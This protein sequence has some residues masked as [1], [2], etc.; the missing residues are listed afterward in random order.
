MYALY[1]VDGRDAGI[2]LSL[3]E[4]LVARLPYE[5][6]SVWRARTLLGG[7]EWFGWSMAE[8]QRADLIDL[9][10]LTMRACAQQGA[11]LRPSEAS[12]RPGGVEKKKE[13]ASSSDSR[14][15]AAIIS[16]IG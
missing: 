10:V 4:N 1:G 9:S 16:S 2:R 11:R 12:A 14:S 5:P 3:V 15:M 8:R 7:E 6:R 13:T